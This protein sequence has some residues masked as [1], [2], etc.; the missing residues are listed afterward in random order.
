MKY[1]ELL[2]PSPK[3]ETVKQIRESASADAARRDVETFVI[4][5]RMAG[6]L[7]DVIIPNLQ[8]DH[9]GDQK[10]IL[11][12]A[13]YGTGKTHLMATIA[14]VAEFGDL[15]DALTNADVRDAARAIAGRFKVVRFDIGA[16]TKPLRE[17]VAEELVRG[18]AEM[19]VDHT[20]PE[21]STV[22]DTKRPLVDMMASFEEVYPEHGL[23]FVLD[24][25]LEYLRGRRD[26]E[27]IQ[28]L[29]FLREVGEI[30]KSTRFRI[31]S[32]VQEA[33]FDNPRFE[34]VAETMRRVRHRFEQVRI[35]KEDVAFVVEQRLLRK[36]ATQ[37]QR[38]EEHLRSFTPLFDGMAERMDRFV[39]LFPV[40]PDYLQTFA[41]IQLV[42]KRE[43]LRTIER[44]VE[45]LADDEVPTDRPGLICADSFRAR[46]VE[47]PSARTIP[48]VQEVLDKSET[49]R[50]KVTTLLPDKQYVDTALRIVDALA[51]H[52]LTTLDVR[53]PVGMTAELLR[54][55]LCLLPPGLPERDAFFLKTSIESIVRKVLTA[56]SGLFISVN[57]DNGQIY[58]DLDKET[59]YD[60]LIEQRAASL[61][62]GELDKAYYLA[63]REV[64]NQTDAP[65][66]GGY[67]IW[68][69]ALPWE[70]T[71]ADR[72]GYL[73]M[74]APNE[75]ST[76]QP[77]RD[78]YVYFLQP[79]DPPEF[80]DEERSDEVF[81]RLAH[82]D[83]T[84]ESAL[85]RY[86]GA[87]A[88]ANESSATG[89]HRPIYEDRMRR[90]HREL[91]TWLR[92]HLATA[93]TVTHQGTTEPLGVWLGR[94]SGDRTTVR[95]QI[96]A[97][98]AAALRP[99]FVERY[100]GYPRFTKRITPSTFE[101]DV[102]VAL[103][104]IS[105]GRTTAAGSA[106]LE[107]LE[108]AARAG[109]LSDPG[110]LRADGRFATALLAALDA[111]EGRVV[112]RTDVLVELDRGVPAWAPWNLEPGWLVVVAAALMQ[113]GKCELGLGGRRVGALGLDA[114]TRL[115]LDE[116]VAFDHLA[117]P[118]SVPV[119]ELRRVA[120]LLG[121]NPAAIPDTGAT[122]REVRE[123]LTAAAA[124]LDRVEKVRAAVAD[125]VELW[126]ERLFDLVDERLR[127]LDDLKRFL[128]DLRARNTSGKM[129]TLDVTATLPDAE[130]GRE[131]LVADE[132]L[133]AVRDR[134]TSVAE[135][136]REAQ[137]VFGSGIPE[138][139]DALSLRTEVVDL[140][141]RGAPVDGAAVARLRSSA[142]DLRA[143]MVDLASR[144]YRHDH[145]D[146]VGDRR[147]QHLV[148]GDE[149][150]ALK[151]LRQVTILQAAPLD[152]VIADLQT[153]P[154]LFEIDEEALARSV[155]LPGR[156]APR[157]ID[158]ASAAARL[159]HAERE[160]ASLLAQWTAT[161]RE[162]LP[163]FAEQIVYLDEPERSIVQTI[164]DRGE[165]PA[166]ITPPVITAI[167]QVV[168]GIDV[169]YLAESDLLGELFPDT[170]PA[171][172]AELQERL[173]ALLVRAAGSGD[174]SRIRFL[175]GEEA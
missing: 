92:E 82:R 93:I 89:Q 63:M 149:L 54:D 121:V 36:D 61:D 77:P 123:L 100:P 44:E 39:A 88:K 71:N 117:P 114:L 3:L 69:Y 25:M 53:T 16:T 106:I 138:S 119:T 102:K 122:D 42:E 12:V 7:T 59:D 139:A 26:G 75:R 14:G 95:D 120:S 158:G 129:N 153:L 107:A 105:T 118:T 170:S 137:G 46:L 161:L 43:V 35:A 147:K 126:G 110:G 37:R 145:L 83:D 94:V 5:D 143:R 171:T 34:G 140:L 141:E 168:A 85:R 65:Y 66:V 67:N 164:V 135:Y 97:V 23:L 148:E 87:Q 62:P 8:F 22:N 73:F 159:E 113:Q 55:Q 174:V 166:R 99:H 49:L 144:S 2:L 31:I 32:G 162:N 109:T 38:I 9:P 48:E 70:E 81:L 169:R 167:N 104:Q 98:A 163:E 156:A 103:T 172:A 154:T 30:C 111:A 52:R 19:G 68:A 90:A 150:E 33:L 127:R 58:L 128:V 45:R 51:V 124:M 133:L 86:A 157:P 134:L 146:A 79:F 15:A 64:L 96:D 115:S 131:E 80:T 112:N 29:V 132:D 21:W 11:T 10:G 91:V 160:V 142:E 41:D 6:Q 84:F 20:F 152:A 18:L 56:V 72:R 27:L 136:L 74:G 24:E 13:T 175:P 130:A 155:V 1:S 173:A 78:F 28:D 116:L 40:H 57:P 101:T 125:G 4:S 17:I 151:A 76:A 47:D 165:L 108:V 50:G 60:Q